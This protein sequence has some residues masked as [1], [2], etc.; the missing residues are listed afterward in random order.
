MKKVFSFGEFFGITR[1]SFETRSYKFVLVRDY[2]DKRVPVHTH[3]TTRFPFQE[4]LIIVLCNLNAARA[5]EI[6]YG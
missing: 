4:L 5:D 2:A 3:K 6:Q 1:E